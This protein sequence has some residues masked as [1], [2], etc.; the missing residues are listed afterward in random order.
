MEKLLDFVSTETFLARP[1]FEKGKEYSLSLFI[2]LFYIFYLMSPFSSLSHTLSFFLSLSY[3]SSFSLSANISYLSFV[4]SLSVFLIS[5][6]SLCKSYQH[7]SLLDYL[8]PSRYVTLLSS[9]SS[10]LLTSWLSFLS[11]PSIYLI[12]FYVSFPHHRVAADKVHHF[13]CS[14]PTDHLSGD[15]SFF[16]KPDLM[17]IVFNNS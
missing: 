11:F 13:L 3:L 4:V 15:K 17:I 2:C 7:Q 6:M 5:F 16:P 8:I 9:L 1:C 14:W 10:P 12:L